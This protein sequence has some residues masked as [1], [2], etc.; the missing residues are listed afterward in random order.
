[1]GAENL[2]PLLYSYVRFTKPARVL[3]VGAG[4]TSMFILQA[5][6]DNAAELDAYRELRGAG[7]VTVRHIAGESNPADLFTKIL[8]RQ[9]FE[10]H[11]KFVLNLPGD[12][13]VEYASRVATRDASSQ[14]YGTGKP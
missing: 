11:R 5:L 1:M 3:E 2:G 7:R 9:P 4:Y 10:K 6:R 13:S 8:A 14:R 12:A